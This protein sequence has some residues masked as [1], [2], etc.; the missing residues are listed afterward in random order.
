MALLT[1][2]QLDEL[3]SYDS[4]TICNALEAFGV[5]ARTE[6]F[7]LP[8]L[9]MRCR[10]SSKAMV[11]YACTGIVTSV[12]P[13][14]PDNRELLKSYY[15]QYDG[16]DVPTVAV[17]QD[18]DV[19][20]VGSFWGDVQATIHR[21]LGCI[22]VV[23]SGGVRDIP[24]VDKVGFYMLSNDVLVSHAMVH[25]LAAG[26]PVTINGLIVKPGDLIHADEHG[27]VLIPGQIADRVAEACAR[28]M[29]AENA[30]L[31]PCREALEKGERVTSDQIM[32]WRAR[33]EENR[34]RILG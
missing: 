29:E 30:V 3:A 4:P 34:K 33:M 21:A 26:K 27:A 20:A 13:A 25:L 6:G 16:W 5:T 1:K 23:T 32:Q 14:G 11:G 28:A 2:A 15:A 17:I 31:D 9:A 8:G 24:E 10:P 12:T 18:L 22:G 19:P 7:A